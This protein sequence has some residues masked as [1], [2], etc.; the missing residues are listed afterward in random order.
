MSRI[1]VTRNILLDHS[2]F[3]KAPKAELPRWSADNKAHK[4]K[5][6]GIVRFLLPEYVVTRSVILCIYLEP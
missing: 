2:F 3:S 1:L 4:Y 6:D 5:V